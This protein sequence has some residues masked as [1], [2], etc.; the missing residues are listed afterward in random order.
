MTTPL[1][2]PFGCV[3]LI[4]EADDE[5]SATPP[6]PI[7]ERQRRDPTNGHLWLACACVDCQMRRQHAGLLS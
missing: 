1:P 5:R 3:A 7:P 2:L 4:E 6:A